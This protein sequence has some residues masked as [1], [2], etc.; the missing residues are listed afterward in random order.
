M[1]H[2]PAGLLNFLLRN[3]LSRNSALQNVTSEDTLSHTGWER[4]WTA[5]L[6]T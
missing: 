4:D 2:H 5:R 1:Y 6:I 3:S